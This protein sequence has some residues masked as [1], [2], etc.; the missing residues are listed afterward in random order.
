MLNQLGQSI[1]PPANLQDF[2]MV[3]MQANQANAGENSLQCSIETQV[4]NSEAKLRDAILVRYDELIAGGY[5]VKQL[6]EKAGLAMATFWNA[7]Q[8]IRD[9]KDLR[10]SSIF[11]MLHAFEMQV[12]LVYNRVPA[13]T[14]KAVRYKESI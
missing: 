1:I 7:L 12:K 9:G 11:R 13:K 14:K 5:T 6:S 10:L 8:R 3:E 4:A 2:A